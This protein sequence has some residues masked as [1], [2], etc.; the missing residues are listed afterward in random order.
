MVTLLSRLRQTIKSVV[1]A[2]ME[3][4]QLRHALKSSR[5]RAEVMQS[6][7]RLGNRVVESVG[8]ESKKVDW[9]QLR[10]T[11]MQMLDE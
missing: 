6:I 4:S 3:K 8:Q 11:F 5:K 10:D 7:M 2:Q 1:I 9:E